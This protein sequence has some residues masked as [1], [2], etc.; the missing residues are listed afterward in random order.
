MANQLLLVFGAASVAVACVMLLLVVM[1]GGGS[2]TGVARSLAMLEDSVSPEDVGR[3]E[4]PAIDRLVLPFLSGMKGLALRLSPSGT[5]RRLTRLLDLAG[6]PV[7]WTVERLLG[8]KGGG[9]LA[10]GFLGIFFGGLSL[11]GFLWCALG[12]TAGFMLPDLLLQNT[13]AKRQEV[14]R[15]GL[16]DAAVHLPRLVNRDHR[17]G[18]HPGDQHL[19]Q[20]VRSG[21]PG[22]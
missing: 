14:L 3:D 6:N 7:G 15:R 13:G 8:L 16:A 18:R 2:L 12:A 22:R 9:L 1:V 19:Q 20:D 21:R 17:P 5:D 11:K 10:G 4:V